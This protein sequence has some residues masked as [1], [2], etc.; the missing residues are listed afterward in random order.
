MVMW[1]NVLANDKHIYSSLL[2]I[3]IHYKNVA[4]TFKDVGDGMMCMNTTMSPV[5][6][7]KVCEVDKYGTIRP[8]H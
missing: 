2:S 4:N 1:I 3:I 6:V 5:V 8:Y 7:G